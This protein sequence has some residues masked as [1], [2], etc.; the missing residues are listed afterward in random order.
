[1]GRLLK[2]VKDVDNLRAAIKN[3]KHDVFLR[4]VDGKEEFNMKSYLSE[5]IALGRLC[6]EGGD[7]YELFC[8]RDDEGYLMEFFNELDK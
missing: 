4:S 8:S 2:N 1:M 5:F 7:M 6:D 3:C